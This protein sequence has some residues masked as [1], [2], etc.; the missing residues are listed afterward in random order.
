M[1]YRILGIDPGYT[2]GL[3]VLDEEGKILEFALMPIIEISKGKQKKKYLN[4]SE[5]SI[6]IKRMNP[7]NCY[8]EQ[9]S[10]FPG[11]G[12]CSMFNFGHT[13]GAIEMALASNSFPYT[14]VSPRKWSNVI[15]K[16]V[17]KDIKAKG[18]S[19]IIFK[20]LY[21]NVNF[22]IKP[23]GKKPEDGLIDALLIA[24]YGRR[25]LV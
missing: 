23:N 8:V 6:L 5:L 1:K 17:S 21:P 13:L 12:V 10:A 11:Q 19:L 14:L 4:M 2:G 24:E 20:R 3:V 7:T 25:E 15:H 9:V 22:I 16:G 18:R